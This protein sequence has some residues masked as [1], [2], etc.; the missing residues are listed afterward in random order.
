VTPKP[1]PALV[2]ITERLRATFWNIVAA[3][4]TTENDADFR[5]AVV[6][7]LDATIPDLD[8]L[9]ALAKGEGL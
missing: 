3:Q 6:S 8:K 7:L 9:D 4:Q 5:R 2:E 1:L